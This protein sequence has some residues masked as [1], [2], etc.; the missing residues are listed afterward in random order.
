[1]SY[2][3][4]KSYKRR[5]VKVVIPNP[6]AHRLQ[7]RINQLRREI[8]TAQAAAAWAESEPVGLDEKQKTLMSL[9][10]ELKGIT[11]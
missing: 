7:G 9:E 4:G 11:R 5:I 2:R 6:A 10:Q 8:E 3:T 1:M